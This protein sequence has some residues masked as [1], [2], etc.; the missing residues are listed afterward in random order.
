MFGTIF[1]TVMI[2]AGSIIGG[3]IQKKALKMNTRI[4]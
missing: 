2:I 3:D 1:N 4:F